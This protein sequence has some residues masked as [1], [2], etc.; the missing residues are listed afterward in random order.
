MNL[1]IELLQVSIGRRDLLSVKPSS[2]DW[3]ALFREAQRQTVVGTIMCGLERLPED[4]RPPKELLLKWYGQ[5]LQ[6]EG[7]NKLLNARCIELEHLF[8]ENGFNCCILKGQGNALMYPNP[9][10][11]QSGDI[12]IWVK[13][14]VGDV[15]SFLETKCDMSQQVV[16]YHH[17]EF[18][19]WEDVVVEVHWRP[20]WQSSPLHNRRL[21]QWFKQNSS[22]ICE[23]GGFHIPTWEFNVVYQL[24][25][26]FLHVLQ[27]GLGLRQ[28]MDYFYLLK[29]RNSNKMTSFEGTLKWLGLSQFAGAMMYVL[30][31]V[32]GMDNQYMIAP[33]NFRKGKFLLKEIIQSGNF[34]FSDTRNGELRKKNGISRS[35]ARMKRDIRFLSY[36]PVEVLCLPFQFYHVIWRKLRLW[37]IG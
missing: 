7:R 34:G 25:H 8:I 20:S 30:K 12:D 15:I 11:R 1:F 36:Y 9:L 27:E 5:T 22:D 24:Q 16:G 2:S 37:R 28:V 10:R 3:Q 32:F 14:R 17:T 31:E 19:I 6:I 35:M 23:K 26:M 33:V 4:Q 13:G 29:S 21:Q 18:P